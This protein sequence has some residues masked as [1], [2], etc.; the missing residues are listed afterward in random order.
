MYIVII[1]LTLCLIMIRDKYKARRNQWRTRERTLWTLALLGGAIGGWVAMV[2]SR[3]KTNHRL[4]AV[5]FA[6]LAMVQSVALIWLLSM[7]LI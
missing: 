6:L 5:G 4:F 1:N 3:H 7:V 2:L